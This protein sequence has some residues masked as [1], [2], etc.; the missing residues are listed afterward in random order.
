[1]LGIEEN[2]DDHNTN[3]EKHIL[4]ETAKGSTHQTSRRLLVPLPDTTGSD[5][6]RDLNQS[7]VGFMYEMGPMRSNGLKHVCEEDGMKPWFV[8]QSIPS[9]L[10]CQR[11]T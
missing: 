1:M 7:I 9:L 11:Q 8:I 3:S 6:A 10:D 2:T 4:S 5:V